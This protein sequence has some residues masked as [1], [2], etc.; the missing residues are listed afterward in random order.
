MQS[1][2]HYLIG[3]FDE[4]KKSGYLLPNHKNQQNLM[5]LPKHKSGQQHKNQTKIKQ[6]IASIKVT[7]TYNLSPSS[8]Q[9]K[10]MESFK[11]AVQI[12]HMNNTLA[13]NKSDRA[14]LLNPHAIS[15]SFFPPLP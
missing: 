13:Q 6:K 7:N 1:I 2:L 3:Y 8:C 4:Q 12:D 14:C 9:Q 11:K 15:S 10:W 5:E